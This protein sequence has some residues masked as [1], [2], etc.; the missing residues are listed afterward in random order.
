MW[1][2]IKK[3]KYSVGLLAIVLVA[4]IAYSVFY[5]ADGV[6]LPFFG[7]SD[8]QPAAQDQQVSEMRVGEDIFRLIER[9]EQIDLNP[10]IF[11][12]PAFAT[13]RDFNYV[14]RPQNQG[15]SDPFAPISGGSSDRGLIRQGA[16]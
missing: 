4:A 14:I 12:R 3:N 1:D 2:V 8:T 11:T 15:R 13:L 6:P 7:A 5:V 16:Q 10:V 9:L